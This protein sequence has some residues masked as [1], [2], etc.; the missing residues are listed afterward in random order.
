[1]DCRFFSLFTS[2]FPFARI[3]PSLRSLHSLTSLAR[4]TPAPQNPAIYPW[5]FRPCVKCDEL[6]TQTGNISIHRL[7]GSR[8][9]A[10]RALLNPSVLYYPSCLR[11]VRR[12]ISW[13]PHDVERRQS[14]ETSVRLIFVVFPRWSAWSIIFLQSC[15][16]RCQPL[17]YQRCWLNAPETR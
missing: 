15:K 1:M 17:R 9:S 11:S 14:L 5:E 12:D 10:F 13:P 6:T 4:A 8:L 2:F 7:W 3:V 16:I